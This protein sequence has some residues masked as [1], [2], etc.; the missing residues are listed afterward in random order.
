MVVIVIDYGGDYCIVGYN[1]FLDSE[2]NVFDD[3]GGDQLYIQLV[4]VVNIDGVVVGLVEK[5]NYIVEWCK[6]CVLVMFVKQSEIGEDY[7]Y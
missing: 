1:V 4:L 7:K 5:F 6:D 3:E 2:V